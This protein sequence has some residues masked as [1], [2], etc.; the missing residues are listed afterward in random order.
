MTPAT[1]FDWTG[2][3]SVLSIGFYEDLEAD[4]VKVN[5]PV[6]KD[7]DTFDR[8]GICDAVSLELRKPPPNKSYLGET[9]SN[10]YCSGKLINSENFPLKLWSAFAMVVIR[11]LLDIL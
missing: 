4:N 11:N 10:K 8:V 7:E 3:C 6:T 5:S 9:K 1:A 2:D